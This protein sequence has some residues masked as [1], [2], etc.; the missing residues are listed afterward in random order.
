LVAGLGCD[1]CAAEGGRGEAGVGGGDGG[2]AG[3]D[4]GE[5]GQGGGGAGSG[6]GGAPFHCDDGNAC[7]VDSVADGAC[8]FDA[9]ADDAICED[10]DLC[11]LGDRCRAGVCVAGERAEGELGLLGRLDSLSGQHVALGA[12]RFVTVGRSD[13]LRA[14]VQ[15]IAPT[16]SGFDTLSSWEGYLGLAVA[17][18]SE[19]LLHAFEASGVVAVVAREDR[20]LRLFAASDAEVMPR[21]ELDVSRQVLSLVGHGERLWSCTYEFGTGYAVTLI[22]VADPDVPVEVGSLLLGAACGSVAMSADG[23][24]I[25]VETSDGVRFVDAAPLDTGGDPTLSGVIAPASRISTSS[26]SGS[27]LMLMTSTGVSI[28]NEPDLVEVATV[29]VVRARATTLIGDRLLVE[30]SRAVGSTT[31]LFVAWY[32]ALGASAP[33]LIGEVVLSTYQGVPQGGSFRSATD[34]TTVI[35]RTRRFDLTDGA[36]DEVRVPELTPLRTLAR[37]SGGLRAYVNS[38][39]VAIDTSDASD[40][41]F[42]AGGG[43]DATSPLY[44]VAIDDSLPAPTFV[45]GLGRGHEDPTRV[46]LDPTN[47]YL[48]SPLH[49]NRCTFDDGA[50]LVSESS[51]SLTYSG[52]SQLLTAGDVMYRFGRPSPSMPSAELEAFWLPGLVAESSAEP[53]FDIPVS[54]STTQKRGFDVDPRARI[55]AIAS[56][57]SGAP[58][59]LSYDV[60]T[61]PPAL[62]DTLALDFVYEQLRVSGE[63]VVAVAPDA[64]V[65]YQR[66]VGEVSR[67]A[68]VRTSQQLLAFDGQVAYLGQ[69]HLVPGASTY[70][71]AA[72]TFGDEAPPVVLV[73]DAV[74]T[75]LVAIDGGLALGFETQLLTVHPHCPAGARR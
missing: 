7:T 50:D 1:G 44:R 62:L 14:R 38:A 31:E 41:S 23:D 75:S 48:A 47:P 34:G 15:V 27:H 37:T 17:D 45:S 30:G 40:P 52:P 71:L 29:P 42:V 8:R 63:R 66:G 69:L 65:F 19:I 72:F 68:N 56:D 9:A 61:S 2:G 28:L 4:S 32:D 49:I 26:T 60:S 12:G 24:R 58:V 74:A 55:A 11:T 6:G 5:A 35:I 73:V 51:F 10:G 57:A 39:V 3:R 25:Y 53:I 70:E 21:G 43:L 46:V 64:I 33:G 18:P 54:G 20:K 13:L 36:L 22:D 16:A 67:V 59:L